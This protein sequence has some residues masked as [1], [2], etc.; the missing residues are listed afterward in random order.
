[1]PANHNWFRDL[2]VSRI[3]VKTLEEMDMHY[4]RLSKDSKAEV[5]LRKE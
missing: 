3:I 2:L 1:M 4:P 5:Q